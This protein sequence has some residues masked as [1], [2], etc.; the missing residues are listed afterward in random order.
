MELEGGR[1][2]GV[3]FHK[4]ATFTLYRGYPLAPRAPKLDLV[5]GKQRQPSRHAFGTRCVR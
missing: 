3:E 1:V 2:V 5:S 4:L